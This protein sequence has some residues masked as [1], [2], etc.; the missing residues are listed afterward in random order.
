M[1]YLKEP[2]LRCSWTYCH[3]ILRVFFA[4]KKPLWPVVHC[5]HLLGLFCLLSPSECALLALPAQITHPP[6]ASQLQSGKG[7]V[8]ERAQGP[9]TAHSHA[10][11]LLWW[12]ERLQAPAQGPVL[13][14]AIAGPNV[15]LMA[16]TAGTHVWKRGTQWHAE[17]WRCQKLLNP[18]K[19]LIALAQGSPRSGLPKGSRSFLLLI[20]CNVASKVVSALFLCYSSFIPTV[21]QVLCSCLM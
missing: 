1:N 7:C 17:A 18:K 14:E 16:F 5:L 6:P 9:A 8:G 12:D 13:C 21:G 4:S 20:T 11:W 15:L 2:S 10:C 19:G 3:R